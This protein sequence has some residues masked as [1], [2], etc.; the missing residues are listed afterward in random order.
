MKK[1]DIHTIRAIKNRADTAADV[2]HNR[3]DEHTNEEYVDPALLDRIYA[4]AVEDLCA[5]LLDGAVQGGMGLVLR[6]G[7]LEGDDLPDD[8]PEVGYPPI[9]E[10]E[11]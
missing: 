1:I 7:R 5:F 10:E 2:A 4:E 8:D 6:A 11:K 9:K 3:L